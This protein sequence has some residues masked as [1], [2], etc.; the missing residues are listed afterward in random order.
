MLWLLN[1]LVIHR[2]NT[3]QNV[4]CLKILVRLGGG[5]VGEVFS[6]T[7]ITRSP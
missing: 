6:T 2:Q 7:S 1:S 3:G 4:D 5:C